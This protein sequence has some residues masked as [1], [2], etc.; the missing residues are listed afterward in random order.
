MHGH[1]PDVP[2]REDVRGVN[3][4]SLL[5]S[6]RFCQSRTVSKQTLKRELNGDTGACTK[7]RAR[8]VLMKEKAPTEGNALVENENE[9]LEE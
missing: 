4:D 6:Q 3:R 7:A 9:D 1:I 5:D 2:P 8:P